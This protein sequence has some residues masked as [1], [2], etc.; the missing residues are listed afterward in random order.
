MPSGLTLGGTGYPCRKGD[1]T[2]ALILSAIPENRLGEI[3]ENLAARLEIFEL[4]VTGGG[5]GQQNAIKVAI[6][7]CEPVHPG[8]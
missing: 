1:K 7:F 4:V 8:L 3:D 6:L 2:K 5:G